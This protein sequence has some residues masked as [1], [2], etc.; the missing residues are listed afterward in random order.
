MIRF[1]FMWST[2]HFIIIFYPIKILLSFYLKKIYVK[3]TYKF[4]E[5]LCSMARNSIT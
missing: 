1:K 3:M 5:S 2:V 4:K